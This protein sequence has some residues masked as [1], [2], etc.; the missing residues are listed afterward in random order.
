MNPRRTP[1]E[2]TFIRMLASERDGEVVAAARATQLFISIVYRNPGT[3]HRFISH[4]WSQHLEQVML[5]RG[6]GPATS[7]WKITPCCALAVSVEPRSPSPSTVR[8]RLFGL[9]GNGPSVSN[10]RNVNAPGSAAPLVTDAVAPYT[11]RTVPPSSVGSVPGTITV[12]GIATAV[13][14]RR[15]G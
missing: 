12:R 8:H 13:S 9:S 11:R 10:A 15:I 4:R 2:Q 7:S 5:G 14:R 1:L 3:K 6:N